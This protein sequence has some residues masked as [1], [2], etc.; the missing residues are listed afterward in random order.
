MAGQ[1]EDMASVHWKELFHAGIS[2][3]DAGYIQE[4][5][6]RTWMA[7]GGGGAGNK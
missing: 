6:W 1:K 2:L 4:L 3:R 5:R 7:G